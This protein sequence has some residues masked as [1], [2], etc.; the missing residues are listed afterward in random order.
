MTACLRFAKIYAFYDYVSKLEHF[1][2]EGR[3]FDRVEVNGNY[4]PGN[5]R[6]ATMKEQQRNRRNN[7]I[8]EYNGERMTLAEY[9][10]DYASPETKKLG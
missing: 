3:T 10:E 8:V 5:L 7:V 1:G 9:R 4:E 2:E 6:W